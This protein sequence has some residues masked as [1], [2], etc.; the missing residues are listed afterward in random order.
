MA[1]NPHSDGWLESFGPELLRLLG[2][3]P[4]RFWLVLG[5]RLCCIRQ[6]SLLNFSEAIISVYERIHCS[7][8][9]RDHHQMLERVA[10]TTWRPH[11]LLNV[12]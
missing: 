6:V 7:K 8:Q 3:G 2:F 9:P 4:L 5:E 11:E 10:V 12:G 1:W